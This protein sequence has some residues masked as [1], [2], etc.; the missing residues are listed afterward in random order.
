MSILDSGEAESGD[1]FEMISKPEEMPHQNS[2]LSQVSDT[3]T[4]TPAHDELR[5]PSP[6]PGM[7]LESLKLKSPEAETRNPMDIAGEN[8]QVYQP[9]PGPPPLPPRPRRTSKA[10]LNAGL[11][12]GRPPLP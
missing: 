7:E 2:T 11:K 4:V 10:T 3:V 5:A 8:T 12:F 6:T 1:D 9:P